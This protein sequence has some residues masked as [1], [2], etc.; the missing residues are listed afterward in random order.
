MNLTGKTVKYYD[1]YLGLVLFTD[2]SALS[3]D[4]DGEMYEMTPQQVRETFRD[5]LVTDVIQEL[6]KTD[7][8]HEVIERRVAVQLAERGIKA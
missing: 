7:L 1:E 3:C 5:H 2:G 6:R 8:H 4:H